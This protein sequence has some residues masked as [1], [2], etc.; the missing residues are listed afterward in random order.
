MDPVRKILVKIFGLLIK[1]KII[2]RWKHERPMSRTCSKWQRLLDCKWS[3]VRNRV[4]S[5]KDSAHIRNPQNKGQIRAG[6]E[7]RAYKQVLHLGF[8]RGPLKVLNDTKPILNDQEGHSDS[9]RTI[10]VSFWSFRVF[11][12]HE[13]EIGRAFFS[14]K[15]FSLPT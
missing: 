4:E 11:L 3:Q 9:F 1:T 2:I 14:S 7:Y 5:S 12:F 10:F 6:S 15:V 8:F 13:Q